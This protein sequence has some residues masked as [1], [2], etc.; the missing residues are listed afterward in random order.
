MTPE[1]QSAFDARE[2][3]LREDQARYKRE[4]N[5]ARLKTQLGERYSRERVGPGTY[6]IYH[7]NQRP[8]VAKLRAFA[9]DIPAMLAARANLVLFGAMGTGK[10]HLMAHLLYLKLVLASP[11]KEQ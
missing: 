7:K 6:T 11:R 8:V 9:A 3:K 10:D 4:K 5:L 2:K 1:E